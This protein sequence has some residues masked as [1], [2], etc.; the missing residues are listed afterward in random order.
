ML[1][2][3]GYST[4][5]TF[6]VEIDNGHFRNIA[7]TGAVFGLGGNLG[8]HF[9]HH[10]RFGG[11]GYVTNTYYEN[12]SRFRIGWGGLFTEYMYR[13]KSVIPYIGLTIGG[14][15]FTNMYF[16]EKPSGNFTTSPVLYKKKSIFIL[17]PYIG[18]EYVLTQK[19]HLRFRVDYL[20]A[21]VAM[22]NEPDFSTG[23]RFYL[24]ISFC[25]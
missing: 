5:K 23:I 1:I 9:G 4:G 24:G 12:G 3:S 11:E 18:T 21:P 10:I 16:P 2:H 8:F 19:L 17:T 15:K 7:A 20:I 14:G 13:L 25:K 22:I 6:Q